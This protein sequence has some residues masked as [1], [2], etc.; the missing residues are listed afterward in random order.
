MK[1]I[2]V[3]IF[4]NLYKSKDVPYI[5]SLSKIVERIKNGSS[6]DSILKI[7]NAK[8]KAQKDSHKRN[9]PSILFAGKFTERNGNGLKQHSGLMVV[10]FDKYPNEQIMLNHL[11]ELKKINHFVLLFIFT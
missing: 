7:R 5:V 2:K 10:D 1:D 3:S 6:K 9:L 11:E 8:N 4:K